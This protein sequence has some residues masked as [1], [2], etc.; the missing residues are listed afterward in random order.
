MRITP[1]ILGER[2]GPI[3]R[4]KPFFYRLF[5]R[6]P[7][8]LHKAVRP[9]TLLVIACCLV[10]LVTCSSSKSV[11]REKVKPA[12]PARVDSLISSEPDAVRKKLGEPTVVSKT[13]E[14]HILWIYT[15]RL[16]ILPNDKGTVYVEFENG[17]V[18]K[19][20]KIE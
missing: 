3:N 11:K 10:G 6:F 17:K 15:P 7:Q 1:A 20:F 12:A 9:V 13:Q 8:E 18:I 14:D 16:K 2:R 5:T 19:V 4:V